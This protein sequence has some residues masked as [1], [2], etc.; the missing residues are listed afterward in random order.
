M[1]I[2]AVFSLFALIITGV[3][4]YIFLNEDEYQIA[5]ILNS[6]EYNEES[7][8]YD[9]TLYLPRLDETI[10]RQMSGIYYRTYNITDDQVCVD[11][12]EKLDYWWIVDFS[13]CE[14]E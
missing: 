7:D 5:Y 12:N 8:I 1:I 11:Y 4:L 2:I 14:I 10:G 3:R 13:Y 9:L 6:S